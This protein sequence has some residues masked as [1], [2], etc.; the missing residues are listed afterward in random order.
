MPDHCVYL[1]AGSNMDPR[2]NIPAALVRLSEYVTIRA[3]STFYESEALQRPDQPNFLNGVIRAT[4]CL[5]PRTLKFDVIRRIEAAL[6]RVRTEDAYAARPIDL[7]ILLYDAL[8]IDKVGLRIP[9]PDIRTRVFWTVPL[10]ELD[11]GLILPD[12]GEPIAALECLTEA[13]RL[14]PAEAFTQALKERLAL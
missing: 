12:T 14:K 5:D 1:G 7:D 9:D 13:V 4:T 2:R 10:L 6:G 3:A 8:I 11:P